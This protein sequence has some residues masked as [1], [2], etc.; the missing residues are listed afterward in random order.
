MKLPI[1]LTRDKFDAYNSVSFYDS[2]AIFFDASTILPNTVSFKIWG[3]GLMPG[4]HWTKYLDL[5]ATPVLKAIID[6]TKGNEVA[7][8]GFGL[9]T[10]E[11]VVAGR[12]SISPYDKGQFAKWK[13]GKA[14]TFIREWTPEAIDP[15]CYEYTFDTT[16]YFPNGACELK[17]Y[18]K[19]KAT[20]EF[21]TND[22]VYYLDYI[23]NPNRRE[24]FWGYLKD[25]TLT[26]NS[27]KYE[28]LDPKS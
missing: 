13:Y 8:Q 20:F 14:I 7:I 4:F 27:Y 26:T 16:I 9:F 3:A 5:N 28:D 19:G 6:K 10:V 12:I 18:A 23:T 15:E 22:C 21:D 2:K 11:Q 1:D 24:T 25:A 17:L